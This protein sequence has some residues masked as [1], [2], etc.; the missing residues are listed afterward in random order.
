MQI[1][2]NANR[3]RNN[4]A[5]YADQQTVFVSQ[6]FVG[7]R[8]QITPSNIVGG[9]AGGGSV[10]RGSVG[11]AQLGSTQ[12]S[13]YLDYTRQIGPWRVVARGSQLEAVEDSG[14]R[15]TERREGNVEVRRAWRHGASAWTTVGILREHDTDRQDAGNRL[16]GNAGVNLPI[17]AAVALSAE[18]ELNRQSV[19][20][21]TS[22]VRNAAVSASLSWALPRSLQLVMHGRYNR[23]ASTISLYDSVTLGPDN[24]AQFQEYLS[25]R[26]RSGYEISMRVQKTFKWHN[27]AL[28]ARRSATGPAGAKRAVDF[29]MVE[30]VVFDDVN[31]NGLADP[32]EQGVSHVTVTLDGARTMLVDA[33]GSFVFK[34]VPV[35]VHTVALEDHS[36]PAWWDIG[37]RRKMEIDV[38][39]RGTAV[40]SFPLVRLGKLR[41]RVLVFEP[42]GG[43][44]LASAASRSTAVPGANLIVILDDRYKMTVTDADGEFEFT[45]LPAGEYRVHI[46]SASVPALWTPASPAVQ[47]IVLAP[48]AKI[49]GVDFTFDAHP[50]AV[51]R[52]FTAS[53]ALPVPHPEPAPTLPA[54]RGSAT[55][56]LPAAPVGSRATSSHQ[57]RR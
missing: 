40:T 31:R 44:T 30:G 23:D 26:L 9:R 48:G 39:K 36:V 20:L 8:W 6:A 52:T 32:G 56:Q 12:H 54:R 43:A 10:S 45:A 57:P 4:V 21:A 22:E 11:S 27:A 55:S 51:R 50:R 14:A 3:W 2:G 1:F 38:A 41:G 47:T 17:S 19:A 5:E 7:A 13:A 24:L 34:N 16:A 28:D 42:S 25:Q 35:G 33:E 15:R 46:D 37:S 29:G 53:T 49:S 18:G